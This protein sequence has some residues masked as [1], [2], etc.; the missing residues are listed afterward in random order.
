MADRK[1]IEIKERILKYAMESWG[2]TDSRNMDP[3][4]DLLLDVFAYESARLHQDIKKLDSRILYQLSRILIDN[5]WSLPIPAHALMS[6]NP[7]SEESCVLDAEDHFY[8]EK[9]V[10]GKESVQVFFTPLFSYPLINAEISLVAYGDSIKINSE[11]HSYS[12]QFLTKKNQVESYVV[13]LGISIEEKQL[14]GLQDITLCLV[15]HDA[16]LL[17]FLKMAQFYDCTGKE[18]P[19]MHGID[20]PD[21]FNNAHYYEEIKNFYS[22]YY[23]K[24]NLAGANKMP[25]TIEQLFP[26]KE[27]VKD[28]DTKGKYFWI[29][30]KLPEVFN[31]TT[32]IEDLDIYLN[33]FPVVNR[34]MLYKQHNFTSNGRII[35]LPSPKGSYFLSI[36]SLY[37]NKGKKYINRLQQYEENPTGIFDLYFGD[38]ERFDSD[39]AADLITQVL[40]RIKEDGNAFAALNPDMLTTSLKDLFSKLNEVEKNLGAAIK[41]DKRE[42]VFALTVP[43]PDATSAE[44]KFWIT[45]GTLAN[46]LDE[47]AFIQ[48]FNMEKYDAASLVFRT[49]VQGGKI[50]TEDAD[51][52]HSLRYG[53][54]SRDRI[55]SKQDIQNYIYHK[56]GNNVESVQVKDGVTISPER[57][58]G[59]ARVM[60]IEI[61]LKQDIENLPDLSVLAHFLEKD[62]AERSVCNSSYKIVFL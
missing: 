32:C 61:R 59:F 40:Q 44:I 7:S 57:K 36:R 17:T 46:G 55:V 60:Q 41:N 23:F 30:I 2:I 4:V 6:V 22:N 20:I 9:F 50:H 56:I 24:I 10:F 13:W 14:A 29:K 54:I 34:R 11:K 53:L 3:V 21:S 51:L 47:R 37:D 39:N 5:K 26:A 27:P 42:R 48:Q 15:P 49:R 18:L 58:K 38:L 45:A 8:T 31:N 28:V 19:V 35:P 62:M 33:T 16:F 1:L 25:Q 12:T 43:D 52:I